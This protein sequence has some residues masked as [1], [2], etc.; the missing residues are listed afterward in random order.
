MFLDSGGGMLRRSNTLLDE[1]KS[2]NCRTLWEIEQIDIWR[3]A[4]QAEASC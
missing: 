4:R 1:W 3:V 2:L